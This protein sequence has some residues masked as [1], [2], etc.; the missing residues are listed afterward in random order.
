MEWKN[1]KKKSI[2]TVMLENYVINIKNKYNISYEK[3]KCI[4]DQ[5]NHAICMKYIQSHHIKTD[6]KGEITKIDG[7]TFDDN[8]N[9]SIKF[10]K[11]NNYLSKNKDHIYIIESFNGLWNGYKLVNN[12]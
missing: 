1:I 8:G 9:F 7:I 2:K 4:L 12:K 3:A 5:I 6:G 11:H 10:N